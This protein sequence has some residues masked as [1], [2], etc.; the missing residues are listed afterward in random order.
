L[1]SQVNEQYSVR[2]FTRYSQEDYG[3]SF[4]GY[5]YD[6]NNTFRLG[7]SSD[8]IVSPV[9]TLHGGLNYI[10]TD[11]QDATD[12]TVADLDQNLWNLNIGFSYKV[13]DSMY[14][15]GSYNY[16]NSGSDG[17]TPLAAAS[18]DYSQNRAQLGIRYEF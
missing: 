1:R 4:D 5:S 15:T 9:L 16:T 8:Y 7:I 17:G 6:L 11:M 2:A 18:R 13:N 12:V 10:I 14:V 3:T